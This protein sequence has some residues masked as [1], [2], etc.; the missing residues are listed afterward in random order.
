MHM[1]MHGYEQ[2]SHNVDAVITH[3]TSKSPFIFMSFLG[4]LSQ[5]QLANVSGGNHSTGGNYANSDLGC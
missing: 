3:Y 4:V 1:D 2:K 5:F